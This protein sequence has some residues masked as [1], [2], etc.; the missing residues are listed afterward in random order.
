MKHNDRHMKRGL[1]R[2]EICIVIVACGALSLAAMSVTPTE[3]PICAITH[4]R[5]GSSRAH[6]IESRFA[7]LDA[8]SS[9]RV[10]EG[11]ETKFEAKAKTLTVRASHDPIPA[12]AISDAIGG[13]AIADGITM[14]TCD[15]LYYTMETG[16]L[17]FYPTVIPRE[18]GWWVFSWVEAKQIHPRLDDAG[19]F[20]A[21]HQH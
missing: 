16:T 14:P 13:S 15:D 10:I 18:R 20:A 17:R 1:S 3:C 2:L 9:L 7:A 4:A 6:D 19:V 5:G 12:A 11:K 8:M 21:A